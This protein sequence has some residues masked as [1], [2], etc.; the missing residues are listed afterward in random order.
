[1]KTTAITLSAIAA[2]GGRNLMALG[3]AGRVPTAMTPL[4]VL[5]AVAESTGSF[6]LAGST[7]AVAALAGALGGPLVGFLAD[8]AGH[9]RVVLVITAAQAVCLAALLGA[10]LL[11]WSPPLL[12]I[13]SGLVGLFNPAI[14]SM[15][16]SRWAA[17]SQS[18]LDRRAYMST[19]MAWEAAADEISF[20]IG[21]IVA[22][23]LTGFGGSVACLLTVMLLALITQT[24]F[25]LVFKPS[26]PVLSRGPGSRPEPPERVATVVGLLPVIVAVGAVGVVFG[27]TQTA[28]AGRFETSGQ[29]E[30]TG[31]VYGCLGIGSASGAIAVTRLSPRIRV[32]VRMI[33]FGSSLALTA[34]LLQSAST[35][36]LL[37]LACAVVGLS[38]SPI[39]ASAYVLT[40]HRVPAGTATT[41]MTILATV[42]TAGV[43]LG[44][45]G[46]GRLLDAG[47]PEAALTLPVLSGLIVV[48]CGVA[49]RLGENR[50]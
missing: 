23:I 36:L 25:A 49:A 1:M 40:E 44:A 41:A 29:P 11:Q 8:R 35:P 27:S 45:A 17:R 37:A 15:A 10:I 31:L 42:T 22:S 39:L 6:A 5:L 4:A 19:A 7:V 16:R 20:V 34:L 12:L 47:S 33:G 38:V 32:T 28:L 13:A 50:S 48:I 30:L 24:G 26:A 46:A 2:D 3:L 9:R 18:R 14:G 43:G 21:P